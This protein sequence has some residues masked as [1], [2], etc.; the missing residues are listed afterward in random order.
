VLGA[1]TDTLDSTGTVTSTAEWDHISHAT[2]DAALGMFR[3]EIM[4]VPPMY[5]ALKRDGKKL[6]DLARKGIEVEREPRPI[7]IYSLAMSPAPTPSHTET[8]IAGDGS[9]YGH[10]GVSGDAAVVPLLPYFALEVSCSGGTYIRTLIAD[11]ARH[12][13]SRA[14]MTAL[15]RTRQGPFTLAD[16]LHQ[17]E[18]KGVGGAGWTFQSL[19]EA[20]V[21]QSEE[22]DE[23]PH[24]ATLKHA[25]RLEVEAEGEVK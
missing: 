2:I 21:R 11:I 20:I 25:L 24:S 10:G 7:T 1:E 6:Y 4:Q 5:S 14:H 23:L 22:K 9:S 18:G 8:T 3:G 15:V 17:Q 13:E 16:C 19:C 12:V